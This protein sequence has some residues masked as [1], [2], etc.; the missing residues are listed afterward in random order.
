M[1]T[2]TYINIGV[3]LS[4]KKLTKLC[5]EFYCLWSGEWT[6]VFQLLF[7]NICNAV[8]SWTFYTVYELSLLL[9]CII[10]THSETMGISSVPQSEKWALFPYQK[11]MNIQRRVDYVSG[12]QAKILN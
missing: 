2:F 6:V 9:Q 5:S 7:C 11:R 10:Q 3:F 4:V 8:E 12:D 1:F